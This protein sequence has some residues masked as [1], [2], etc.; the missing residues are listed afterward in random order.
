MQG[1]RG[2]FLLGGNHL[3]ILHVGAT[4]LSDEPQVVEAVVIIVLPE[5]ALQAFIDLG[6]IG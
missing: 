3:G 2:Q 6:P 5:P 1:E 4:R